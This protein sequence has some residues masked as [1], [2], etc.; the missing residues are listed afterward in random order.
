VS[1][2]SQT[3][4][5][6]TRR[7][8]KSEEQLLGDELRQKTV[9]KLWVITEEF[10]ILYK[11]N[12]TRL[13][14]LEMQRFQDHLVQRVRERAPSGAAGK[15]GD[16]VAAAATRWADGP[17][18][19]DSPAG[20]E[21][22]AGVRVL[23]VTHFHSLAQDADRWTFASSF[24]YALTLITTIGEL[25]AQMFITTTPKSTNE[26]QPEEVGCAL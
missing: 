23:P 19:R 13:A 15:G 2:C 20:G 25:L 4:T 24:L 5:P 7:Q 18:V 16:S 8:P 6:N 9:E 22:P 26:A 10:N 12:W 14:A 11:D 1:E 21:A 17:A 3:S